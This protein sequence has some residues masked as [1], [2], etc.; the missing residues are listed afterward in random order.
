M[1]ASRSPRTGQH[2]LRSGSLAAQLV[3]SSGIDCSHLVFEIGAGTGVLTEALA[4]RARRV[5]AVELE[6]RLASRL[7]ERLTGDDRVEVR[8]GDVL[9]EPLP[10]EP[11]RAA[12][13]VPFHLTTR[14]LHRLLDDPATPLLRADLIVQWEAAVKRVAPRH[15]N[16]LSVAWGAWYDFEIVRRL[17]S[18]CFRPP[19]SVDAAHLAISRRPVPLLAARDRDAFVTLLRRGFTP[20]C[21]PLHR[22]LSGLLSHTQMKRLASDLGFAPEARAIDLRPA[23]WAALFEFLRKAGSSGP[24]STPARTARRTRGWRHPVPRA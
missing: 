13:N 16:L 24:R 22:E 1:E 3:C 2:L 6:P 14:I 9:C 19:P 12:G 17:P 4:A 21:G 5:V 7:S 23:Q 15:S 10:D 20:S 11:F 18:S 8:V